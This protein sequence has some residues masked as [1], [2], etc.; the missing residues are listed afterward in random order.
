MNICCFTGIRNPCPRARERK[1]MS[2]SYSVRQKQIR[3]MRFMIIWSLWF[4]RSLSLVIRRKRKDKSIRAHAKKEKKKKSEI[5]TI[6]KQWPLPLT[7]PYS[8]LATCLLALDPGHPS[9]TRWTRSTSEESVQFRRRLSL[10][11]CVYKIDY[12]YFSGIDI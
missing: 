12:M 1:I 5:I 8:E 10:N 11:L 4:L 2:A 9:Y 7:G 3:W 6:K